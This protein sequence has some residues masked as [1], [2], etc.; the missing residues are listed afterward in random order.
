MSAL[1]ASPATFAAKA[2]AKKAA[3]ATERAAKVSRLREE[4][5]QAIQSKDYDRAKNLFAKARGLEAAEE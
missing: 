3:A 1:V 2:E 5:R 4:A